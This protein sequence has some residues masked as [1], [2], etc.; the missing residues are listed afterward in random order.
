VIAE[1]ENLKKEREEGR[2]REE[3]ESVMR[4]Q[5]TLKRHLGNLGSIIGYQRGEMDQEGHYDPGKTLAWTSSSGNRGH[6][7]GKNQRHRK[8]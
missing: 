3:R 7:E 2:G 5:K 4:P 1:E 8:G 6:M